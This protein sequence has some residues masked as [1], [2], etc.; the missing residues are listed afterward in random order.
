MWV[1]KFDVNS[2][3]SPHRRN[4][5]SGGTKRAETEARP[6][7]EGLLMGAPVGSQ[8]GPFMVQGSHLKSEN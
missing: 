7:R 6:R 4:K 5:S 1:E 8:F 2:L 3:V